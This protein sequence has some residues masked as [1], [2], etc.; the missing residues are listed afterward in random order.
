MNDNGGFAPGL[1]VGLCFGG[2]IAIFSLTINNGLWKQELAKKGFAEYTVSQ[3][4]QV[5][6]H[7]KNEPQQEN[8]H[9][10]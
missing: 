3:Q 5:S 9:D 2:I 4:G 8:E 7:Y 1:M 6:W 10:N